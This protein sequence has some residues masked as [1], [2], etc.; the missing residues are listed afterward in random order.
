M[1][2]VAIDGPAGE[3]IFG[4]KIG[5]EITC[6]KFKEETKANPPPRGGVYNNRNEKMRLGCF[7]Y[8]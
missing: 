1:F 7:K 2:S 5:R 4:S 6:G 8:L 3:P